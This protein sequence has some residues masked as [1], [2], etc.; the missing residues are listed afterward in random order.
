MPHP[1]TQAARALVD[2]A[3]ATLE[4]MRA[5]A[6]HMGELAERAKLGA[7]FAAQSAVTSLERAA[8]EALARL[9][10]AFAALRGR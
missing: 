10:R 9:D 3:S 5:D 2:D 8:D 1:L 4:R 6:R 7:N